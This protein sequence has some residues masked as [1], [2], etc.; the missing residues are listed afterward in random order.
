MSR[1]TSL[2]AICTQL[3][4]RLMVMLEKSDLLLRAGLLQVLTQSNS[5]ES[6]DQ[7]QLFQRMHSWAVTTAVDSDGLPSLH[8]ACVILRNL[9]SG[10]SST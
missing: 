3:V 1:L 10:M 2:P 4:P 6:G 9:S 7:L 5:L 8:A